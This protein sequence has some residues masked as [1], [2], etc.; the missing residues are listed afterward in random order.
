MQL[1][2]NISFFSLVFVSIV[3]ALMEHNQRHWLGVA[4]WLAILAVALATVV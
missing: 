1:I 4:G 3:G 2:A